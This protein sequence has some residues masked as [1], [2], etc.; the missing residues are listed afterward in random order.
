VDCEAEVKEPKV[1][2]AW[3]CYH[4]GKRHL[5]QWDIWDVLMEEGIN[6]VCEGKRGCFNE[7]KGRIVQIGETA[8][9]LTDRR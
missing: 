1:T 3:E 9:A 2:V 4:C 5:W 8:Y 6:M 7:T